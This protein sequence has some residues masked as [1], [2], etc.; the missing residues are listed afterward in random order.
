MICPRTRGRELAMD[1]DV[2]NVDPR[3]VVLQARQHPSAST[4]ARE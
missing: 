2:Y 1:F 4:L 3:A